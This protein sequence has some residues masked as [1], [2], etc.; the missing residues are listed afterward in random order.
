MTSRERERLERRRTALLAEV[1][2]L[3]NLMRGTLYERQR[4]CGRAS[5]TCASGGP[6]H[7]GLQLTVNQRGRTWTRFVRQSERATV[8]EWLRNYQRLWAIIE[9]LTTINL[10]L[11]HA[12]PGRPQEP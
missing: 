9:E 3:P 2:G 4:K 12:A 5:C 11:L 6:R 1:H 10:E 8:E 7:P